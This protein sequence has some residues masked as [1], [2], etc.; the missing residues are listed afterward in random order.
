MRSSWKIAFI[1]A[2]SVALILSTWLLSGCDNTDPTAPKDSTIDL[3]ANPSHLDFQT[4][5]TSRHT[6]L[7]ATVLDSEGVPVRD[8]AV[9]F[10]TT[11]GTLASGGD[12]VKTDHNGE[13]HDTLTLHVTDDDA[14]VKARA[15]GA[16]TGTVTVSV[17]APGENVAPVAVITP[18]SPTPTLN[19]PFTFSGTS[20]HD[21]DGVIKTYDWDFGDSSSHASTATA[22]HTDTHAGTFS[23]SLTVADDGDGNCDGTATCT[24]VKTNTA[25]VSAVVAQPGPTAVI[26]NGSTFNAQV[27]QAV[28]LDATPSSDDGSIVRYDWTFGDGTQGAQVTTPTTTHTWATTGSFPITLTVWDNGDGTNCNP[29]THL[30]NGSKSASTTATVTVQ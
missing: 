26:S 28:T 7:T 14:E 8:V 10:S 1:G 30:C 2:A 3:S 6:T 25:T 9:H 18:T 19:Q 4:G 13:A 11:S 23:V 17:N 22:S 16:T 15:A 29:T 12:S 20:S 24:N 27:N 21:S 5:E